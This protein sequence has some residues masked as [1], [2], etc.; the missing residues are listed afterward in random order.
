MMERDAAAKWGVNLQTVA[1]RTG[2]NYRIACKGQLN[3]N[4]TPCPPVFLIH[5]WPESWYS[6]RHQ[7]SLADLGY[8]V[9]A[10]D[11]RGYGDSYSPV[12]PSQYSIHH[13]AADLINLKAAL[14]I[15][16][17]VALI[18]HD[19]GAIICWLMSLLFPNHFS[20][21]CCLSVPY[22][23]WQKV[24]PTAAWK[25]FHGDN[26]FYINYHNESGNVAETEYD[27]KVEQFLYRIYTDKSVNKLPPVITDPK[28]A[29][30]GF[31]DRLPQPTS[32]PKWLTQE[33]LDYYVKEFKRSGFKG[34]VNYYRNF[35]NNWE[36]TSSHAGE[37]I[38]QPALFVAGADDMV[39]R[40][41]G[42]EEV[43]KRNLENNVSNLTGCHII[44]NCGHWIQ[45]EAP[46][47]TNSLIISFLNTHYP[48]PENIRSSRLRL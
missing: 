15:E 44:P 24:K 40:M 47:Q 10:P 35:D 32:L 9:C 46:D 16:Q 5:G 2:I 20:V 13:I 19:W 7:F 1:L 31:V 21:V 22:A 33:D 48:V 29:A 45:Q 27:A 42:G 36:F 41:F 6:W 30:G 12:D 28:R 4:G 38:L 8:F 43:V 14:Q 11:M 26:F 39:I 23:G 37:K 25:Q 17:K 3:D 34:G 18:G